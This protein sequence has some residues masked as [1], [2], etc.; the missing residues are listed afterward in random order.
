MNLEGSIRS[1]ADHSTEEIWRVSGKFEMLQAAAKDLFFDSIGREFPAPVW[2]TC[3]RK[4]RSCLKWVCAIIAARA[5]NTIPLWT[6][7]SANI[8]LL[9]SDLSGVRLDG[10]QS[11]VQAIWFAPDGEEL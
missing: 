11:I 4:R 10:T 2:T 7:V 5:K 6:V 9:L 3:L 8:A 1:E